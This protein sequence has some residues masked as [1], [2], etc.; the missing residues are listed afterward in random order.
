MLATPL[1]KDIAAL[2]TGVGHSFSFGEFKSNRGLLIRIDGQLA[3]AANAIVRARETALLTRPGRVRFSGEAYAYFDG[4]LKLVDLLG[5]T[6]K[7]VLVLTAGGKQIDCGVDN[8]SVDQLRAALDRR[9]VAYG[10]AHYGPS[11]GIPERLEVT[12]AEPVRGFA[13]ADLARWRGSFD[14][15]GLSVGEGLN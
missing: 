2:N 8:L 3:S 9:V 14:L 13:E 1:L 12:K 7:A 15:S 11:S 4:V 5:E 6:Q 10:R